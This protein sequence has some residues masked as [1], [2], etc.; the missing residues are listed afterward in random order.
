MCPGRHLADISLFLTAACTLAT[1]DISKQVDEDGVEIVPEVQYS[2]ETIRLGGRPAVVRRVLKVCFQSPASI[3]IQSDSAVR[4]GARAVEARELNVLPVIR[5]RCSACQR[6]IHA[7]PT[8][9]LYNY[10]VFLLMSVVSNV[11]RQHLRSEEF[12]SK[13]DH[14]C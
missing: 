5:L 14:Q 12:K 7:T 4:K 6:Y 9:P 10:T 2:G 13:S 8:P 1:F 11:Q 3:P